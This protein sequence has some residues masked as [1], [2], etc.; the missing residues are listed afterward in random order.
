MS[1]SQTYQ[2]ITHFRLQS[3]ILKVIVSTSSPVSEMKNQG[4]VFIKLQTIAQK[5][6]KASLEQMQQLLDDFKEIDNVKSI[7]ILNPSNGNGFIF[8]YES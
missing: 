4:E 1:L 8:T 7:E 5:Y 3:F 6:Q 2:T